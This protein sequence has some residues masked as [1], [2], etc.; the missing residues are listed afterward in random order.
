[1]VLEINGGV[2][3]LATTLMVLGDMPVG[4]SLSITGCCFE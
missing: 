3:S 1:M 2:E 4:S